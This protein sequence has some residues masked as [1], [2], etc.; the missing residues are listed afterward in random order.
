MPTLKDVAQFLDLSSERQ[1]YEHTPPIAR[2]SMQ[3]EMPAATFQFSDESRGHIKSRSWN[4]G[5]GKTSTEP[6][7]H[8][9]D[10][11]RFAGHIQRTD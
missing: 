2:F 5:D 10:A 1:A 7:A 8:L 3:H 6:V 11:I 9:P 4:F